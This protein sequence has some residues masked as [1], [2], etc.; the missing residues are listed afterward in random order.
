MRTSL[1]LLIM[2]ATAST[3]AQFTAIPQTLVT[4]TGTLKGT[5]IAPSNISKFP[6]L[7]LQ[8]GSG[9]TDRNGN[10]PFGLRSNSYRLLAEALATQNIGTLLTDKRGIAES[11]PAGKDES[12]LRFTDYSDDMVLW[13][14]QLKKEKKSSC[15]FLAGHSEGSLIAMIAASKVKVKGYISLA[16]AGESI[17]KILVW[18]VKQQSAPI[19]RTLDSLLMRLRSQKNIDTV[20]PG[21]YALLRP[22]VQPYM[23]SWMQQD[24]CN[25]MKKLKIPTFIIQGS[26][27]I[28]VEVAQ[29]EKLKNCKPSAEFLLIDGMS[30]I[31]KAGP[32]DRT[33]NAATYNDKSL[34]LMPGLAEAIGNFVNKRHK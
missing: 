33:K 1:L 29:Y 19:A 9:P 26:N 25:I 16:G 6:I 30:H 15:I 28:Q 20:P 31:L 22:S 34:P 23:S 13:V 32:M 8:A 14:K 5:L 4:K 11:A 2:L 7:I 17:D 10:S 18:Q 12:A 3:Q 21:L 24:P 27:D